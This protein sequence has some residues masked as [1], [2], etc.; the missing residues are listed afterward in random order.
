MNAI[1]TVEPK[2]AAPG[3]GLPRIE[4]FI[5]RR[6]FARRLR[7]GTRDSFTASFQAER[8]AI[9]ALVKSCDPESGARRVLIERVRGM[10]DSSRN[11]SV[12]MTLDH[13]RIVNGGITCTIGALAKGIVPPGKASTAAVKPSPDV[14]SAVISEY[15]SSCDAFLAQVAAIND[16]KTTA[17]FAHPWFG[18]LD[19][20]GWVAMAGN[21]MG[22]H[23]VQM[24]RIIAGLDAK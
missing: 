13:L 6:L 5:G 19:A 1:A 22:I 18:P 14:T 4:L 11:W 21:H 24:E 10:E 2:L 17:R 3:A 8:A 9:A 23:R 16:L 12:W 15:E 7:R 20:F